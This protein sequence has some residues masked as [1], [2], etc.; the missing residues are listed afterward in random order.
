M[1][2]ES[3]ILKKDIIIPKGTIIDNGSAK[4]KEN[5]HFEFVIGYG[6]DVAMIAVISR[7]DIEEAAHCEP[8]VFVKKMKL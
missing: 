3:Y 7:S 5:D 1:K 2:E 6:C 4:A 8:K